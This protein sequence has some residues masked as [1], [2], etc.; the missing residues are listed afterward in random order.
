MSHRALNKLTDRHIKPFIGKAEPGRK[1][2]DGGG[3]FLTLTAAR[4]PVWRIK[5]RYAGKEQLYTV[6]VYPAV[7]LQAARTELD[8]VKTQLREGRDPGKSRALNKA[9]A[10]AATENTLAAVADDWLT[11]RQPGSSQIHYEKSKRAIQRDVLPK[12]GTLPVAEITPALIASV[13]EDIESRGARDTAG[14]ILQHIAAIFRLAQAR[15]LC[16]DNP[17]VPAREVLSKRAAPGRRAALLGWKSLGQVLRAADAARLSPAVRIAHRLCAYTASRISNVV[18]ADWREFQLEATPP[19]WTIPRHK[20]KVKTGDRPR[21]HKVILGPNIAAELRTW[22]NI[23]GGNGYV[24]PSPTGGKHITRESLE[25]AY[26]VTMQLKDKH[27]PHGWRAALSTLARDHGFSRD[28]VELALDHIHDSDVARAYDRG[29]RFD[30]RVRLMHWWD[31][32]L[33]TAQRGGD[34]VSLA[35]A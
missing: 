14:K 3:M 11:K 31:E 1:L 10:A 23:A 22:R 30:E 7:S 8:W 20:M 18:E 29:E 2:A 13:I 34:V 27:T 25:K 5:Y 6:G 15:G 35:A 33:T 24:F 32:H 12:V 4:T 28:A 21:E 26:R 9:A 16:R 17:A 19:L